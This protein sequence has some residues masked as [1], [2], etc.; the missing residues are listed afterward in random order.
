MQKK[1]YNWL[2][3]SR[4][5]FQANFRKTDVLEKEHQFCL[6]LWHSTIFLKTSFF[7]SYIFATIMAYH[8]IDCFVISLNAKKVQQSSYHNLFWDITANKKTI[9]W[10]SKKSLCY[11]P[12]SLWF[13]A[14]GIL[15]SLVV[16]EILGLED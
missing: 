12:S 5:F 10:K 16:V 7:K 8:L 11:Q 2:F 1:I 4:F 6:K 3:F 9:F 14:I 13:K 15:L